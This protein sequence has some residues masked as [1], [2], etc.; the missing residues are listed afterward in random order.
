VDKIRKQV[1]TIDY[2]GH[3]LL[4]TQDNGHVLKL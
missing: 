3:T 4:P 2:L 1:M